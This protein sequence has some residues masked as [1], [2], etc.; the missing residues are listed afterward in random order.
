MALERGEGKEC[1]CT[2]RGVSA[3]M[4][5]TEAVH[6]IAN[7]DKGDRIHTRTHTV[8]PLL[9]LSW[10][11]RDSRL[12]V[13]LSWAMF[14]FSHVSLDSNTSHHGCLFTVVFSRIRIG[15]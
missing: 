11:T 14:V 6:R 3:W 1:Q 4:G 5:N 8:G 12:S 15:H 10:L 7:Y 9:G 13:S 2:D